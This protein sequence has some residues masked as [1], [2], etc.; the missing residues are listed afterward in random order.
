MSFR[1]Y[2][3]NSHFLQKFLNGIEKQITRMYSADHNFCPNVIL[4]Q[5][6]DFLLISD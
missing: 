2:L 1:I 3:A 5:N 6:F 4:K